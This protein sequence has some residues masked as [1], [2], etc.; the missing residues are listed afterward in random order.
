MNV[1]MT[2]GPKGQVVIPK[3]FR[4]ELGL[5]PGAE[6]VF[7]KDNRKLNIERKSEQMEKIRAEIEAFVKLHGRKDYKQI[8]LDEE[9]D[10]ELEESMKRWKL[11]K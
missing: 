11:P 2:V 7:S 1:V 8:N 10:L 4:D 9:L 3:P 5:Y 6:V